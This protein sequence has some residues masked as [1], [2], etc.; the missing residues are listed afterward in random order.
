[1]AS[2][3]DLAAHPH[4]AHSKC[5]NLTQA[6][7]FIAASLLPSAIP[8]NIKSVAKEAKVSKATISRVINNDPCVRP[9]TAR[10]VWKAIQHLN[11]YP[12]IYARTLGSGRSRIL[13]SII[14]DISNPFFPEIVKSFEERALK[15]GYEVLLT[16]TNHDPTRMAGCAQRMLE[17]RVEGVAGSNGPT[18]DSHRLPRPRNRSGPDQQYFRRLL[19]G[20]TRGNGTSLPLGTQAYRLYQRPFGVALGANP[21]IRIPEMPRKMRHYLR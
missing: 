21:Q 14:S 9:E 10:K 4:A 1:M 11:Y 15:N 16:D 17:R 8:A 3:Q 12:N 7:L 18:R 19:P 5:D 13:G 20:N 2:R 6:A